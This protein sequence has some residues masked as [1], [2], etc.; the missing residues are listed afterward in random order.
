[1]PKK[2]WLDGSSLGFDARPQPQALVRPGPGMLEGFVRL[3]NQ[4]DQAILR[5]ARR[6]GPLWTCGHRKFWQHNPIECRPEPTSEAS[7]YTRREPLQFWRELATEAR[8]VLRIAQAMNSGVHGDTDDWKAIPGPYDRMLRLF[9][10]WDEGQWID[11]RSEAIHEML[12]ANEDLLRLEERMRQWRRDDRLRPEWVPDEDPATWEM[13]P[14]RVSREIDD[15]LLS[16]VIDDWLDRGCIRLSIFPQNGKRAVRLA[17]GGLL[18][19]LAVQLVFE[20]CRTDGLAVCTS[21]GTPYLPATRRPRRDQNPYCSDCGIKAA[22]R[23]AAARYRQTGK[24]RQARE[25]RR[26]REQGASSTPTDGH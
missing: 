6:W 22:R 26:A 8:A 12:V 9:V 5:Y 14:G 13:V 15:R 10:R 3:A 4:P 11:E 16:L 21:C 23:D 7:Y 18:G 1:M 20:V 24:Y 17:G 2:L 25:R 19:A